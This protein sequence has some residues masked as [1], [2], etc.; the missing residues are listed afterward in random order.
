MI[1]LRQKKQTGGNMLMNN[2]IKKI[3]RIIESDL[4]VLDISYEI[5]VVKI[6]FAIL[7][8]FLALHR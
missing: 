5:I 6:G 8:L 1:N 4:I 3:L 7:R 2:H